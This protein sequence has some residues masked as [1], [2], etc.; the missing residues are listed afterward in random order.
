MKIEANLPSGVTSTA[1]PFSAAALSKSFGS[2]RVLDGLNLVL[3]SGET[4][5][6]LGSN[7]SGKTTFLKML[8]GLLPADGG[9]SS[10]AGEPSLTLSPAVRSR[11][12]YVPQTPNQF[13]WL[14]GRA[15]LKYIAAFYPTFEWDY[16]NELLERWKVSLRTPIALLSPGQQQRLSIVRALAPRPDLLILDEPIAALDPVTRLAVIDE[17]LN[18]HRIRRI[19]IIFSSHITGDLERLCRR[20]VVLARGAIS[21]DGSTEYCR[22][23]AKIDVAGDE[24]ELKAIDWSAFQHV[25]KPQE[26]QRV[27]ISQRHQAA[28]LLAPMSKTLMVTIQNDD[29]ESVLSEW[30]Q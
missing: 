11:I 4:V 2:R 19:S 13:P 8:L 15:M 21:F 1:A 29:L 12:G 27:L 22:S 9:R 28:E 5:G 16:A 14:N 6:L 7:G 23:L 26:G 24:G 18:E 17:L 10:I 3:E 20:F 25:R 30:M